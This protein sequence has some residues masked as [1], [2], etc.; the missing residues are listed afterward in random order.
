[1]TDLAAGA[2]V[3]A[4]ATSSFLVTIILG[5]VLLR[6]ARRSHSMGN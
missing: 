2:L 5:D 6:L 1:M 3:G 4:A